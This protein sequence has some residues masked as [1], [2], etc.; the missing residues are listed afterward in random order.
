[1]IDLA[2]FRNR[3]FNINLITG[4]FTF[5]TISGTI[6]LMPF[7]M[8][9]VLGFPTSQVGLIMASIP[10]SM[11]IIAPLSGALSDRVGSQ[12]IT[13]IGLIILVGASLGLTTISSETSPWIL[14]LLY[15]P[16]GLG[17][18]IFQSPNNSV[19]LGSVPREQLGVASGL[20]ATNRTLGQTTGIAVL[21]ALFAASVT[22]Y[23]GFPP[24]NGATSAPAEI[25]V[26]SLQVVFLATAV[27][28]IFGTLL[29]VWG[30]LQERKSQIERPSTPI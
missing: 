22:S 23:L 15:L 10:I 3:L 1:M 5:V 19:I 7:Y 27:L 8:E 29:A 28:L 25:Q 18:G 26:Q 14:I 6:I 2:I 24:E 9:G 16:V 20:L 30:L 4:M 17:M 21:G 13:V 12:L 11:G